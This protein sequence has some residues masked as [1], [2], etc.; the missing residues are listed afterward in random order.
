LHVIRATG[1]SSFPASAEGQRFSASDRLPVRGTKTVR[2]RSAQALGG[3]E[4]VRRN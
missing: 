2:I 3:S 1:L 4:A